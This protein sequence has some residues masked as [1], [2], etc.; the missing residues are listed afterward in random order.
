L[1]RVCREV[2]EGGLYHVYNRFARCEEV[3]VDPTE[4]VGFIDRFRD[5]KARTVGSAKPAGSE[6]KNTASQLTSKPSAKLFRPR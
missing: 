4:A 5:T 2:I 3:L 6:T 1:P